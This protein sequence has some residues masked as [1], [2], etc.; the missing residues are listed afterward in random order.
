MCQLHEHAELFADLLLELR[1]PLLQP[2]FLH[3]VESLLGGLVDPTQRPRYLRIFQL[4]VVTNVRRGVGSHGAPGTTHR[5]TA[6]VPRAA[7]ARSDCASSSPPPPSRRELAAVSASAVLFPTDLG[8]TDIMH[9]LE[10]MLPTAILSTPLHEHMRS[11]QSLGSPP[12]P[13]PGSASAGSQWTSALSSRMGYLAIPVILGLVVALAWMH[14]LQTCAEQII[15][16]TLIV[17][18][19]VLIAVALYFMHIGFSSAGV[20]FI[21]FALLTF[22]FIFCVKARIK[23]TAAL[24]EQAVVVSKRHPA[25]YAP[26]NTTSTGT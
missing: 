25:M 8:L 6:R 20:L 15:Y 9:G 12:S 26:P 7:T 17:K 23:L 22:A 14:M 16:A 5:L 24:L 13:P 18:P 3:I 21:F 11:L 19:I 4:E 10:K 2:G 1:Q